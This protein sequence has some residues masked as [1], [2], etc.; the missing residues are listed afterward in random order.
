MA[1]NAEFGILKD[2]LPHGPICSRLCASSACR[3]SR[4]LGCGR[5][6]GQTPGHSRN[7]WSTCL[8]AIP[9]QHA[10]SGSGAD[11]RFWCR[12]PSWLLPLLILP[13]FACSLGIDRHRL[14]FPCPCAGGLPSH[15]FFQTSSRQPF[16][17]L[18]YLAVFTA[19]PPHRRSLLFPRGF[20]A[21][22]DQDPGSMDSSL[23]GMP[24]ASYPIIPP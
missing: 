10:C 11:I 24:I 5:P 23:S 2:S 3:P 16:C 18:G 1:V 22:H 20:V 12:H 14:G 9:P 4:L 13:G 6:M 7:P 17:H 19:L 21:A 15:R 8:H